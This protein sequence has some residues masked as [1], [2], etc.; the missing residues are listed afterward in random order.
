MAVI[1]L[2]GARFHIDEPFGTDTYVLLT[3]AT[4]LPEPEVLKFEGVV[5]RGASDGNNPL[6]NLLQST[7]AGTRGSGLE[8]PTDWGVQLLQV[9][10]QPV[11]HGSAP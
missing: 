4:K 5:Q 3:T 11:V 7:S 1:P 8:A 6:V 9:H 2:P 10:S